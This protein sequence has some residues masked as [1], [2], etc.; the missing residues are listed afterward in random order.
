MENKDQQQPQELDLESILQEFGG[1]SQ[2][3]TQE[4]APEPEAM[5]DTAVL[6]DTGLPETEAP[7]PVSD[8]TV[9]LTPLRAGTDTVVLNPEEIRQA[10]A[11]AA[12]DA[13]LSGNTVRFSPIREPAPQADAAEPY[14]ETWEPEYEEPMGEYV[15]PR[16]ILIHPRSRLN[17][18]KKQL[19]AGPERRY[20]ALSE[21]GV[22]RLQAA[23]FLTLLVVVLSFVAVALHRLGMVYEGRLRLLIFGEV[24]AMLVCALLG[25]YRLME[26]A[27]S[28]L[29][30]RFT[31]ETLLLIT[32]GVCIADGLAC[33]QQ[34]RLPF[35]AAFCL[36]MLFAQLKAYH[37]RTTELAQMDTL[38]KATNLHAVVVQ[39]N[40][41]QQTKGV[42][43]RDGEV[44]DFMDAYNGSAL[45][46]KIM[47]I[48][49]FCAFLLSLAAAVAAG[50][51]QGW[52][53]LTQVWAAALL[54]SVPGT[55]FILYSRPLALLEKRLHK[56]G[57]VLCGWKGIRTLGGK[58][59]FPLED[60][61]LFPGGT[62]T[63]NGVKFYGD[64]EP[65]EILAL[66]TGV[67]RC[68]RSSLE[69]IFTALLDSRSAP[70]YDARDLEYL[71]GGV[72]G[73]VDGIRVHLGSASHLQA[74]GIQLPAG[75]KLAQ[76]VY[77]A[78]DG[79]LAGVFALSYSRDRGAAAGLGALM[80]DRRIQS[81]IVCR[82]FLLGEK[83]LGN[84]MRQRI[85]RVL[86]P[87]R[88]VR[89]GILQMRCHQE[90]P[91]AALCVHT[92]LAAKAFAITG[93]R[94]LKVC[95]TFG[96]V[97]HLTAGILGLGAVAA[98]GILGAFHLVS[99]ANL[100]VYCLL[101][102]VPGWLLTEWTR[103]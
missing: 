18:L 96:L 5:E 87:D 8:D 15:P 16:P 22:G 4:P 23:I 100:L 59:I 54:A 53:Y 11:Q 25:C 63:M 92:D 33:L 98:L 61:D 46:E 99:P 93:A 49:G 24:L 14:S 19:I 102:T 36:E 12:Q 58:L 10:A 41:F 67:I 82:D 47:H 64:M 66:A 43:R 48:Y 71:D 50:Y 89:D 80:G 81:V 28:L 52:E 75:A 1:H 39:E 3:P 27:A 2:E 13:A 31:L 9:V 45:P 42:L 88:S 32:F 101:W 69:P 94:S 34:L 60:A 73:F 77:C 91:A 76:A 84:R 85:R 56:V 7:T 37:S 6:P 78:I 55:A 72:V 40:V 86:F 68:S 62:V 65:D 17:H 30:G 26:G 35:C 70:H 103:F 97:I 74:Q 38:R 79:V 57:A 90:L 44:E 83:L 21:I 20:Y 29:R 95:S 51:Y